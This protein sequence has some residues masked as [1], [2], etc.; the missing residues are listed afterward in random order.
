[1]NTSRYAAASDVG[2]VRENNEDA[3]LTTDTVWIVADGMGGH[4]GGE[5]ASRMAV[6][7]AAEVLGDQPADVDLV[8]TAF[9]TAHGRVRDAAH[10]ELAGMGT[11]MVL[12]C[13]D[14]DG[15]VL[16]GNVGD[17]R[18]YL[19]ADGA[20]QQVTTDDNQAEVLLAHGD[21]T[22]EEARVHPGQYLLTASLGG[23]QPTPPVPAVHHLPSHAGRLL[24]CSDG[25][26]SELTDEQIAAGLATE[27]PAQAATE[28]VQAAVQ[29]GGRDN[30]TVVVIDL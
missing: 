5:V 2:Q 23:G 30:V 29:A 19:L 26:N 16:V 18:A 11:T 13:R 21:I 6:E 25:L 4:A 28:L 22:A 8:A 24:L 10:G 3:A 7:A 14:A 1:M 9:A 12:A 17:S 15:E 20:L 27:D